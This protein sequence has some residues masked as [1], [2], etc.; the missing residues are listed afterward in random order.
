[1]AD[2]TRAHMPLQMSLQRP[3]RMTS[4]K[5]FYDLDLREDATHFHGDLFLQCYTRVM[6]NA[7]SVS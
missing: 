7:C 5:F 4:T 1:V 3:G 6:Q 2:L